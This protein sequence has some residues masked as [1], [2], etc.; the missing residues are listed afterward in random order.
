MIKQ[1]SFKRYFKYIP[2]FLAMLMSMLFITAP[3]TYAYEYANTPHGQAFVD[4]FGSTPGQIGRLEEFYYGDESEPIIRL[5]EGPD[6]FATYRFPLQDNFFMSGYTP[7]IGDVL[8]WNTSTFK[9]E[10]DLFPVFGGE[11]AFVTNVDNPL[12]IAEIQSRIKAIDNED[13]DISHLITLIEETYDPA[14]RLVGTFYLKFKVTDSAGNVANL[15]VHVVVKD[16]AV[17][18]ITGTKTYNQSYTIKKDVGTILAALSATDN[19]DTTNPI[20][21]VRTDNYTANYNKVGSYEIIFYATDTSGNEGTYTVTVSVIDDVK[22]VFTG[23]TVIAKG[24][25]NTLLLADIISQV[26][27]SDVVDKSVT[28][29][30]KSDGYTGNGN[31]VGN[32]PI[33]LEAIDSSGN[34]ATHTITIQVKDNIP[35][36][37]YVD[38]FF[39]HVEDIITLTRQQIIDLLVGTGQLTLDPQGLTTFTFPLNE[40]EGNE[41][42][43]GIY[44]LMVMS[45]HPNGTTRQVSLAIQVEE[46]VED[47]GAIIGEPDEG[48]LMDI[49]NGIKDAWNWLKTP[50]NEESKFYNGYYILIGIGVLGLLGVFGANY[51]GKKFRF[52]KRFKRNKYRRY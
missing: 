3:K 43:P 51:K 19:Y 15:T 44:G 50:V 12:S 45:T 17:P 14:E 13:G 21:K 27:V 24:Q 10:M 5:L 23:P 31:K 11:T 8:T 36:I 38:N 29:T 46:T 33:V 35:P 4:D 39:I 37:Y 48:L 2:L 49:W 34:V 6:E 18:I 41:S 25:S 9:W 32:W 1:L 47:P 16:V 42:T 22:P 40:Y 28:F 30:V 52:K 20:V 26:T 7:T